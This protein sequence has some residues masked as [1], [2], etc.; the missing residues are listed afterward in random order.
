MPGTP[1]HLTEGEVELDG[2]VLEAAAPQPRGAFTQQQGGAPAIGLDAPLG[3]ADG[4]RGRVERL[5][6]APGGGERRDG[7]EEHRA[8][9]R[10]SGSDGFH[11]ST[12]AR[13][14]PKRLDVSDIIGV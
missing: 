8:E 12:L 1:R 14:V 10:E 2:A 9:A 6:V 5:Q 13:L 3:G 11:A 7:H 4:P